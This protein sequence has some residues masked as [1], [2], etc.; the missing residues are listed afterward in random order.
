MNRKDTLLE[1]LREQAGSPKEMAAAVGVEASDASFRRAVK[2]LVA[3][4]T[5]IAEG[6][7]RDRSYV[8]ASGN[9]HAPDVALPDTDAALLALVPCSAQEFSKN[10]R[11]LI[12]DSQQLGR[13]KLRLG[14]ETFKHENGRWLC[15]HVEGYT[16]PQTSAREDLGL[17][18]DEF[19]R[20]AARAGKS[21][22]PIGGRQ[23]GGEKGE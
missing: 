9:G 1:Q 12:P 14:I 16:G 13:A 10:G 4:G 22:H 21:G 18:G 23:K 3:E 2:E 19:A 15:R 6:T 8:N 5:L 11:L 7:T 20:M 17:Q